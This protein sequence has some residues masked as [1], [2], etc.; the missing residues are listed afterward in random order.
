M[1]KEYPCEL[2]K[3][4]MC[5]HGGNKY[6]NYGFVQGMASYCQIAKRWVVDLNECPLTTGEGK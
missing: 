6:Y 1:S 4:K 2:S 5:K 3:T